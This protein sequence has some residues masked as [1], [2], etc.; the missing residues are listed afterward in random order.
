MS[1]AWSLALPVVTVLVITY[2][3]L[4]AG[5]PRPVV[6]VRVYGGPTEGVSKLSLRIESVQRDGESEAPVWNGPLAVHARAANGAELVTSVPRA[7]AAVADFELVFAAPV[8]GPLNLELRDANG[9]VLA[10]GPVALD[11]TRWAARARR[12]GGWIR[13]RAEGGLVISIAP[14][15]GAFVVGSAD[16]LQPRLHL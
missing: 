6:G 15:R 16:P 3:L 1:R 7:T 8:H 4:V 11:A 5:V 10:S 9:S 13:G 12:R 2:A 14:E